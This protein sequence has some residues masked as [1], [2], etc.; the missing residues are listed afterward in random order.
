[1]RGNRLAATASQRASAWALPRDPTPSCARTVQEPRVPVR[2]TAPNLRTRRR[3]GA[4]SVRPHGATLQSCLGVRRFLPGLCSLAHV[5]VRSHQPTSRR[6]PRKAMPCRS[7]GSRLRRTSRERLTRRRLRA[8]HGGA[9]SVPRGRDRCRRAT[10][11]RGCRMRSA[12]PA[13]TVSDVAI[14]ARRASRATS[15]VV[16]AGTPALL[17]ACAAKTRRALC[18]LEERGASRRAAR[19]DHAPSEPSGHPSACALAR[20]LPPV[21]PRIIGSASS[22]NLKCLSRPAAR[23]A[24]TNSRAESRRRVA[25]VSHSR[26]CP[27]A[28]RTARGSCA[29]TSRRSRRIPCS[30]PRT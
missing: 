10:R 21:H 15:C 8:L 24:P 25:A 9:S 26:R 14:A 12:R 2:N 23:S 13:R 30:A 28:P 3:S 4:L 5:P 22:P 27:S 17:G 11:S 16:A 7:A 18:L 20:D 19:P 6:A 1:M 29:R